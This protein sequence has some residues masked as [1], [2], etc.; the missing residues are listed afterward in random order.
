MSGDEQGERT[1]EEEKE[2]E[3]EKEN[4]KGKGKEK[5]KENDRARTTDPPR[6]FSFPRRLTATRPYSHC[7]VI[8]PKM[9]RR[10]DRPAKH[11][12]AIRMEPGQDET[13]VHAHAGAHQ[14]SASSAGHLHCSI[15]SMNVGNGAP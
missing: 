5:E 7:A 6:T 4:E 2:K 9:A 11:T 8:P 12:P 13:Y 1:N 10:S 15:D 14:A 3:K